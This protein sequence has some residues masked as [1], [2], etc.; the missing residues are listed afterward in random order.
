MEL[1]GELRALSR[2]TERVN[3]RARIR[4]E[5]VE[6]LIRNRWSRGCRVR[7]L[8]C[9]TE[10]RTGDKKAFTSSFMLVSTENLSTEQTIVYLRTLP[11]IRGRCGRV[12]HLAN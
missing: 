8:S 5:R 3:P 7:L 6:N 12:H 4:G 2:C 1:E 10:V 9:D 11:S